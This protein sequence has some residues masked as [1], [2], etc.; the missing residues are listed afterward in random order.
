MAPRRGEDRQFREGAQVKREL[1]IGVAAA[2]ILA[3]GISGCSNNTSSSNGSGSSSATSTSTTSAA[4]SADGSAKL[5]I[6]GKD[7]NV[8]PGVQ[9][10]NTPGTLTI[11]IG[12]DQPDIVVVLTDANPPVVNS[13]ALGTINGVTLGY[14]DGAGGSATATKDGNTYKVTGTAT[15][16]DAATPPQPV[17]KPFEI[18]ATCTT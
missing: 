5:T 13:V 14:G 15:G 12:G 7:Q 1:T 16:T 3:A 11:A 2:A 9:C 18:S 6:D 10:A 8:H 17:S 4:A